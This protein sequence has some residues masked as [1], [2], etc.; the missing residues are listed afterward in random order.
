MH[1]T[2][3]TETFIEVAEDCPAT[4]G[5]VPAPRGGRPTVAGLQY[6]LLMTRPYELSS[7]DLLF[8][9][10]AQRHQVSDHERAGAR[11]AFFAKTQAC[12][13]AS[14]L[15]KRHGWG[16]HHDAD[17]KVAIVAVDSEEYERLAADP[18]VYHLRA[19]RSK[20]A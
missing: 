19:M 2:N 6:A 12:L 11:E 17:S 13:R 7:D 1:T 5:E 20:R 8:E 18:S 9:V 15:A 14:P 4:T 3:Y 16:I 10:H